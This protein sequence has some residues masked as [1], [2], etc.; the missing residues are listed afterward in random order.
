MARGSYQGGS[1]IVTPRDLA[2]QSSEK[3]TPVEAARAS[4]SESR[5]KAAT[6]LA[7]NRAQRKRLESST[8]V[9]MDEEEREYWAQI[10]PFDLRWR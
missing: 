10:D 5:S 6:Q 1:T 3:V 2:R 8:S 7:R 9:A 4:I